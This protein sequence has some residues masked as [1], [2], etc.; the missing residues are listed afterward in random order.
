MEKNSSLLVLKRYLARFGIILTNFAVIGILFLI[1]TFLANFL[2]LLFYILL[3]VWALALLGIPLL[4][5]NYRKLWSSTENILA[6]INNFLE[7]NFNLIAI[8]TIVLIVASILFMLC[9]K[10][11]VKAKNRII[12]FC[13]IGVLLVLGLIVLLITKAGGTA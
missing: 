3:I 12:V 5:E 6:N 2:T 1:G 13:I 8:L 4:D 11:W 10:K 9:D 7:N